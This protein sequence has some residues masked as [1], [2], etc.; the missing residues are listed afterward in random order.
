MTI[1]IQQHT[2]NYKKPVQRSRKSKDSLQKLVIAERS[3]LIQAEWMC[4]HGPG[5]DERETQSC[6]YIAC[7]TLIKLST[8]W[9]V[10]IEPYVCPRPLRIGKSKTEII[11]V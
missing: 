9:K 8:K 11:F 4:K 1:P 7:R 6:K 2:G 5:T 3:M 10:I